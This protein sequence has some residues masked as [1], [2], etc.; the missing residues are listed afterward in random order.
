MVNRLNLGGNLDDPLP[1]GTAGEQ[2]KEVSRKGTPGR[3][4]FFRRSVAEVAWRELAAL[5]EGAGRRECR[6]FPA[7][8]ASFGAAARRSGVHSRDAAQR[9]SEAP[10]G[11]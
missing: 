7:N 3:G 9:Q 2:T 8:V 1:R 4:S 6:T 10:R 5:D 11:R